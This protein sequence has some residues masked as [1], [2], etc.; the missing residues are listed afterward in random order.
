M[1]RGLA[2]DLAVDAPGARLAAAA[3]HGLRNALAA[4]PSRAAAG[5]LSDAVSLYGQWLQ[6]DAAGWETADAAYDELCQALRALRR[7]RAARV[8]PVRVRVPGSGT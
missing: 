8:S 2:S 1:A 4:G 3:R 6:A 7:T 5:H